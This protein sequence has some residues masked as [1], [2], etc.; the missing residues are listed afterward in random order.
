MDV[1]FADGKNAFMV[2][3]HNRQEVSRAILWCGLGR[4]QFFRVVSRSSTF[5]SAFETTLNQSLIKE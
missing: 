4:S 3:V 5:S 2:C 1:M